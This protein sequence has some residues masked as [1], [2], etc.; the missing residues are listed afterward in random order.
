MSFWLKGQTTT[1]SLLVEGYNGA[2]WVTIE[3]IVNPSNTAT[4][5]TYNTLSTPSLPSNIVRF[6]YTYTKTTSNLSFD[7]VTYT[8]GT[9]SN[10]PVTNSPYAISD[11]SILSKFVL[12]LPS[13]GTYY[14][15]VKAN[16]GTNT[17]AASN[18]RFAV[19]DII[20]PITNPSSTTSIYSA[21]GRVNVSG[22]T[23]FAVYNTQGMQ[24][25]VVKATEDVSSV[26]L[27]PGIYVVKTA[28]KIQKVVVR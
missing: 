2:T 5:H 6:R 28:G 10:V 3:N 22:A 1:G 16:D 12:G 8:Y 14:Y 23:D 9:S 15:T 13:Y 24:V 4:T 20:T 17:S 7:D 19:L 21:N 27:R 26:A 18:E 25:A 11:G